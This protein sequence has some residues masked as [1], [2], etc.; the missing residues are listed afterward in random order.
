MVPFSSNISISV[1]PRGQLVVLC[2]YRMNRSCLG[3]STII[4][5]YGQETNN[6]ADHRPEELT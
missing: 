6:L 3:A 2:S 5:L 1:W 4:Y